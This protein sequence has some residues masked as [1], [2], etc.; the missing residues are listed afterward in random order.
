MNQ[1]PLQTPLLAF[2]LLSLTHLLPT[3]SADWTHYRGPAS[4]GVSTEKL[5]NG[6]PTQIWKS[7]VGI[8]T[9]SITVAGD[10]LFTMGNLDN[11]DTVWCLNAQTGAVIWKYQYPLDLDKRMFEG[12]TASTP[13]IDGQRLYTVSHQGDLFCFDIK[14]GKPLWQKHYQKDFA[15]RRPQWGYA[16][17]PTVHGN[18][19][20]LDVGAKDASTIALDKLT[21]A[22]IWKS[23]EDLPGY[24]SPTIASLQGNKVALL[25][26]AS[27]LVALQ[28]TTG[29]EL[30][31]TPWKTEYQVNAATPMSFDD[32]VFV[33]SGYGT[34][35]ALYRI[36]SNQLSEVW[37]NKSLKSHINS[38]A[39]FQGHLYGPDGQAGADS[40]LT[41]IDASTGLVQWQEKSVRGGSLIIADGHLICLAENGELIIASATPTAFKPLHRIQALG[42]R[43]WVQP[44]YSDQRIF[45][46]N[47]QGD[48]TAFSLK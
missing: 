44:T 23:G 16:G 48:L 1:P 30:W 3:A 22:T 17:S 29:L 45:C 43:C 9:S 40:P 7:S 46:R 27:H 15:G 47:N 19:L 20:L 6:A 35:S 36:A 31:R 14:T 24:A 8:G 5:P 38:P 41:C 34:G 26:K 21:G 11:L 10:L 37:R 42:K 12:G 4:Q 2:A 13:T 33:S 32:K 39:L 25:F 18:L 28:P